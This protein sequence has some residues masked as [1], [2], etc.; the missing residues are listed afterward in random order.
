MC[1]HSCPK[2]GETPLFSVLA[3]STGQGRLRMRP[4]AGFAGPAPGFYFGALLAWDGAW[5]AEEG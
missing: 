3:L 5:G 1:P 2:A 4:E